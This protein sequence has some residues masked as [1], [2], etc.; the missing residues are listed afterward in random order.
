MMED[1]IK[2]PWQDQVLTTQGNMAICSPRQMGKSTIISEDAG[3]YACKNKNKSIMIIAAVDRQSLLLFEK[4]LSYIYE[5]YKNMIL[6]G[7]NKPT[8]HELKLSNG[9]VIRS[10]PT[11]DSG[12]GIRGY[13]IDRLYADEAAF[14]K[15]DVWAAVTPMLATTG[16]DIILLSTPF[17]TDGYFYRM[18]HSKQFTSIYVDPEKVIENRPEPQRTNLL[19]FRKDEKERMTKLQYQQEHLGLFVGGI[20]RFLSEELINQMLSIDPKEKYEPQGSKAQGIDVAQ[21]GGDD[22]AMTSLDLFNGRLRQFDI[23]ITNNER[24]TAT[25]RLVVHKD[26]KI[27]HNRIYL[28]DGGLGVGLFDPLFE[29]NQTK[30]KVVGLN[31]ASRGIERVVE[32][33]KINI[34][35]KSLLGTD[36]AINFKILAENGKIALFNDPR[37]RQSLRS[38]QMDYSE[39]TLKIYGNFAHIFE[40]LKRA[41]WHIKTK[42]LNPYIS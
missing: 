9:S 29:D 15:E 25:A 14:I 2:D 7:K 6:T 39:G 41:A 10:L 33:G 3:E 5:N 8:K 30:R 38:M 22:I 1:M 26:K 31:N 21:L 24:L 36:M 40:S 18:F 23:E 42:H 11:G 19:E 27:N 4:V 28:D 37:I 13:T 35:N 20:Q 32:K 16:G 34:R 12:Y 17:G